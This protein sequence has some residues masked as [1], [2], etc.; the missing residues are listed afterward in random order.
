MDYHLGDHN[1]GQEARKDSRRTDFPVLRK[2]GETREG[3][4]GRRDADERHRGCGNPACVRN[5]ADGSTV[6]LTRYCRIIG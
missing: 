5:Q 6:G 3:Q 4:T 1:H 2:A